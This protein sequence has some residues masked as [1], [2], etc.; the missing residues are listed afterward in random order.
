M[1][2]A[3]LIL[4]SL[5]LVF[6]LSF[7][8]ISC[9]GN[10]DTDAE[11]STDTKTDSTTDTGAGSND[12]NT[13]SSDTNTGSSDTNT[14]SSDTDSEDNG[15]NGEQKPEHVHTEEIVKGKAATCTEKGLTDGK[16]CSECGEILVKQEEIVAQGHEKTTVEAQAPTCK[17]IGWEAYEKCTRCSYS[18]YVELPITN[19]HESRTEK[20]GMMGDCK[21]GYVANVCDLCGDYEMVQLDLMCN[22][23]M[24]SERNTL[25]IECR[26]CAL[27]ISLTSKTE[28][29]CEFEAS[30][31]VTYDGEVLFTGDSYEYNSHANVDYD[32][33]DLSDTFACGARAVVLKC[34]DCD[35]VMEL[36]AAVHEGELDISEETKENATI[37]TSTCDVC[38]F[39][40]VETAWT[41][42]DCQKTSVKELELYKGDTLLYEFKKETPNSE[43]AFK[44]EYIMLGDS[45]DNGYVKKDTCDDCG[46]S[47]YE[48]GIGCIEG[49][50]EF[51]SLEGISSCGGGYLVNKCIVCKNVAGNSYFTTECSAVEGQ[52]EV[53]DENGNTIV[54]QTVTCEDCGIVY[55]YLYN[56]ISEFYCTNE[57]Y[58]WYKLSMGDT[59]FYEYDYISVDEDP[60]HRT[61]YT[62]ELL[63]NSC[64]DGVLVT[65]ACE[66]GC[67]YKY[68]YIRYNHTVNSNDTKEIEID[69]ACQGTVLNEETC[70]CGVEKNYYLSRCDGSEYNYDNGELYEKTT[71]TCP[72]CNLQYTNEIVYEIGSCKNIGKGV[73]TLIVGDKAYYDNESYIYYD[74]DYHVREEEAILF[75]DSCYDGYLVVSKCKDCG[76]TVYEYDEYHHANDEEITIITTACGDIEITHSVCYCGEREYYDYSYSCYAP[77]EKT[78][79]TDE[80]GF[81]NEYYIR[82]CESCGTVIKEDYIETKGDGCTSVETKYL[83]FIYKDENG[84]EKTLEYV[85][86]EGLNERHSY[87]YTYEIVEN[88]CENGVIETATCV[89]CGETYVDEYSGAHSPRADYG[90]DIRFD[91]YGS[92]CR[93]WYRYGICPCEEA[94]VTF[95]L[96]TYNCDMVTT[97]ESEEIDGVLY[98]TKTD[99]CQNCGLV[100]IVVSHDKTDGCYTYEYIVRTIKMGERVIVDAQNE[101]HIKEEKHDNTIEY[102]LEG[103]TCYDGWY[104]KETCKDCGKEEIYWNNNHEFVYSIDSYMLDGQI[105]EEHYFTISVCLCGELGD[106]YVDA[107]EWGGF[108]ENNGVYSC[109]EC[110]IVLTKAISQTENEDCT[111]EYVEA[112]KVALDGEEKFAKDVTMVF[113]KH[114]FELVGSSKVDG[115]LVIDTACKKCDLA[116]SNEIKTTGEFIEGYWTNEYQF[117][118]TPEQTGDYSLYVLENGESY[119]TIVYDENG[120]FIVLRNADAP[121]VLVEQ[122]EAGKTYTISYG[123]WAGPNAYEYVFLK[124]NVPI[125]DDIVA[126]AV[127]YEIEIDGITYNVQISK[128]CGVVLSY[129]EAVLE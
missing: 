9:G 92:A 113:E 126:E 91:Y 2:R 105:C 11:I 19:V 56:D 90:Y 125:T 124:G 74:S 31:V 88:N 97:T 48:F 51:I 89:D 62:Y 80:N 116:F 63:G 120:D 79:I 55:E 85:Y 75:G 17:D 12:T 22:V 77:A 27:T 111:V 114:D 101:T 69:Q 82:T 95:D 34:F 72:D 67:G 115:N 123:N 129:Q 37:K 40:K 44:T 108:E 6:T 24:S 47:T 128:D 5:I 112:Y 71:V 14:G 68:E 107:S 30:A 83:T 20:Y 64:R 58:F 96:S 84:E 118:F 76:D 18:T 4:M 109:A 87:K 35:K 16:K 49:K 23:E 33:I 42:T 78:I 28:L 61:V 26:D 7:A 110:G 36:C 32:V 93:G 103:E 99:T 60:Y 73:L 41:E 21:S 29:S 104:T 43:H 46:I 3:F 65:E 122:L 39:K 117:T 52:R 13:G 81:I 86:I 15:G 119:V 121:C 100:I 70:V 57:Y 66:Y 98:T 25:T 94:V 59:V 8:L 10:E 54:I 127:D 45:C 106:F 53:T 102:E 50:T 1:K 38:S